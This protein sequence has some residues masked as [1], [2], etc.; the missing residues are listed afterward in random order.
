M[1]K[2][3]EAI[4]R[5]FLWT[6]N[7]IESKKA[8]IAWRK[9]YEPK[10]CG[11]WN[12]INMSFWNKAA[13][14]KL[15]WAI[16]YKSDRLWV[17]WVHAYYIKR[18]TY[19]TASITANSSWL[20]RKII[21]TRDTLILLGGWNNLNKAG[22][23]SITQTYR[24]LQGDHQGVTWKRLMCNNH[25]SPKSKFILW[26][27]LYNRLATTDRLSKWNIPCRVTWSLCDGDDESVQH[28]FF[29]CSYS[30][31]IWSRVCQIIKIACSGDIFDHE[32]TK[33]IAKAR[34]KSRQARLYTMCFTETI[35]AVWAQRNNKIF[36]GK[37]VECRQVVKDIIFKVACL[38][39]EDDRQMLVY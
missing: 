36:N 24:L 6:G 28:L 26:L 11:G 25:D 14:L 3:V 29:A 27:A 33:A 1:I 7:T 32:Y 20:L 21:D 19:S 34:G 10:T 15:L 23:F 39:K 12:L 16:A 13:L 2:E 8:H 35:Y 37:C 22:K 31:S 30:A 9:I 5:R 4:C 18:L 17:K 38:C